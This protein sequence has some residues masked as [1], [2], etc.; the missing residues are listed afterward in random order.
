MSPLRRPN[1][2]ASRGISLT[3]APPLDGLA[4][5]TKPAQR[6]PPGGRPRDARAVAT[7]TAGASGVPE[8]RRLR[9][10]LASELSSQESQASQASGC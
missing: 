2:L 4:G 3:T 8:A 10:S 7:T 9:R 5:L 1:Y 6:P